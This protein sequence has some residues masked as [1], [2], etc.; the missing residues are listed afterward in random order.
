[1]H[2]KQCLMFT[3]NIHYNNNNIP[4]ILFRVSDFN[5]V[6]FLTDPKSNT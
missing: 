5:D 3:W 4:T 6:I 1:M 2:K